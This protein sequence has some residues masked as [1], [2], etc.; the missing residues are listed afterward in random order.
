MTVVRPNSIAGINSITVQTGQALNIHD[1]SGNLIRNITSSSG[2]S[3][4]ASVEITKGTGDLTVG[5][6]TFFVDQ[7]TGK[8]GIGT[9]VP[10]GLL[11][12]DAASTTEMIMLDVAGV[13]FAKIGHNAASGVNV[14]DV[15]SEGHLRVLTG[16]NNE[17]LRL[18]SS[19]RLLLGTTS[20]TSPIGWGNNL[21]VAGTSAV[22][23]V[24]IRRDS[25]DTGGALLV[26]G[27]SRGSLNGSTVVQDGDQIGGMYFAGGDGTDVNSIAA[28]VSVEVDGTPGSNDMPGRILLK[29]TA[30]GAS[31]PTERLRMD[32]SGRLLIGTTAF[33]GTYDGINPHVLLEGTSYD[34]STI[35]LFCNANAVGSAPQLQLG[36]SRGTS[37]GAT[38]IV[39]D[40]DRL[41][42]I[43]I[44]GAD[45]TDRNSAFAGID[46]KVDGTPGAND[47]P[48]RIE[49]KTTS[50][51]ASTPTERM[52]IKSTGGIHFGSA[53][54]V[55][56]EVFTFQKSASNGGTNGQ[57]MYIDHAGTDDH[58]AVAVRHRG[59][60][61]TTFRTQIGFLN[62][63]GAQIGSIR[64]DGDETSYVT[65]SD[66]RLKENAV[67]ISDGIT[68][69][70][71]LKPYRF[72]FKN[73]PSKTRD[74]FFA[75]EAA[76]VIPEAVTGEK[77]QVITQAQVDD[78]TRE[79]GDLGK[80]EYQSMDYARL[81]PLLTA[82]LQE[83]I[84]KIETLE[85]EVAA[86]KSS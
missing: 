41:G 11:E 69:L 79:E 9:V 15:R 50:D 38:T 3:T 44:V 48:G 12:I 78:G 76:T 82:A 25:A 8:I 71:T 27:K 19:G 37:D 40:D 10:A 39:Q 31:S 47:T 17:R 53:G 28:Q 74:G 58:R 1:A 26:F 65:S 2:I 46:F 52:V 60:S 36:K 4:F 57:L 29:T 86:L 14:L 33:N 73:T 54:P 22:A 35:T 45:G 66:Y 5:V 84:A 43:W 32:K 61:S 75:H 24:S 67:A 68:R 34:T 30:D 80:P 72:N 7:S 59:A 6:S 64:S 83:A 49:F 23:G 42:S 63:A 16:G 62:D 20:N 85:T 70:K 55:S 56:A 21:Q 77:D 13:N 81:T 51:G 18:D